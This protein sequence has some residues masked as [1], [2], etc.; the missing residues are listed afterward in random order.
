MRI[1]SLCSASGQPTLNDVA[2]ETFA[3]ASAAVNDD[4]AVPVTSEQDA[5]LFLTR[6]PARW[7]RNG[8]QC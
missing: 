1:P 5:M 2:L 8:R 6:K 7:S 4:R 3:S